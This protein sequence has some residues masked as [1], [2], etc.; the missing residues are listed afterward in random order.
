MITAKDWEELSAFLQSRGDRSGVCENPPFRQACEYYLKILLQ[1]NEVLNLTAVRE[2]EVAFWKHLADSLV[3][4]S[5]EPLGKV[6][7]WGSGGGLP[8]IPL[9]LAR[10]AQGQDANILFL[11]SV[12]KKLKAV[13]EF[14]GQLKI[15]GCGFLNARGEIAI[16]S[17]AFHGVNTVVMRAVAPP[18]RAVDWMDSSVSQWVFLLT[19][20]QLPGW[21]KEAPRLKRK[22]LNLVRSEV[23]EL[24]QNH[25]PRA[26]LEYSK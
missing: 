11:D 2:L 23:Y 9:A 8:G 18:E 25:G 15:P 17:E 22:G 12:G 1:K 14:V 6:V 3:L 26:L 5:W 4:L 10:V 20:Q 7:D 13:E 24:P 19:P 16:K 21:E